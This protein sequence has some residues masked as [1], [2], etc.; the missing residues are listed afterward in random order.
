MRRRDRRA[1]DD[2]DIAQGLGRGGTCQPHRR[3]PVAI[4]G[5]ARPVIADWPRH[6]GRGDQRREPRRFR[7]GEPGY[8]AA[9]L[10]SGDRSDICV[11]R[12]QGSVSV[13]RG[14]RSFWEG[15]D[16]ARVSKSVSSSPP[17]AHQRSCY[18][19]GRSRKPL[20]ARPSEYRQVPVTGS[21][22]PGMLKTWPKPTRQIL[23]SR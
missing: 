12:G 21:M 3:E 16:H 9:S 6:Y 17:A 5:G 2:R 4:G 13:F 8:R 20:A 22:Y 10:A 15:G 14:S 19:S 18:P 23:L 1:G 11:R 7:G